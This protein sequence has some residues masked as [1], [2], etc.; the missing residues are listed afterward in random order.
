[1][2]KNEKF[3]RLVILLLTV[4]IIAGFFMPWL[5]LADAGKDMFD[6]NETH[7]SGYDFMRGIRAIA[8]SIKDIGVA[9]GYP[10]LARVVYLGYLL[11]L[12][13]LLGIMAVFVTVKKQKIMTPLFL[14]QYIFSLLTCILFVIVIFVNGDIRQ[15]FFNLFKFSWGFYLIIIA[16]FLGFVQLIYRSIQKV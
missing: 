7:Y 1:M 8:P 15:L 4:I 2:K 9:F 5:A 10:V 14:A 11:W 16:S 12:I 6:Q 13:P 3:N